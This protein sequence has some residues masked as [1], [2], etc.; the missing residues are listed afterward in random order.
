MGDLS[1]DY[2][3]YGSRLEAWTF[4]HNAEMLT[5]Q[6]QTL[7]IPRLLSDDYGQSQFSTSQDA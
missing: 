4:K 1:N 5:T 2:Q 7:V 6:L 3:F